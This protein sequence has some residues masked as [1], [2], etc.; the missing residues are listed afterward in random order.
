M[1]IF[2]PEINPQT[3]S[4][5]A[6]IMGA[7]SAGEYAGGQRM[8]QNIMNPVNAEMTLA[9]LDKLTQ[10]NDLF[11]AKMPNEIAVSQA[12]GR[13]AN[14]KTPEYFRMR[15]TGENA[16]DRQNVLKADIG[17]ATKESDIANT[18][19][20]NKQKAI[21]RMGENMRD[22]VAYV[23]VLP[24]DQQADAMRQLISHHGFDKHP[25][26]GRAWESFGGMDNKTQLAQM[27][28]AAEFLM[29]TDP[30]KL[31]ALTQHRETNQTNLQIAQGHDAATRYAADARK[32]D[33][34]AE[35]KKAWMKA[36]DPQKAGYLESAVQDA[37][38]SGATQ[39]EVGGMT[40]T[41]QQAQELAKFY[42][43]RALATRSVGAPQVSVPGVDRTNPVGSAMGSLYPGSPLG[44]NQPAKTWDPATKT[45]K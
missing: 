37:M 31:A 2:Q 8:M 29:N 34:G 4:T 12:L 33:D 5:L 23:S 18:L 13:E 30:A 22:M 3:L 9:N 28:K 27:Q 7:G 21:R 26:M 14:S 44:T 36:N 45:W 6:D 11:R 20:E 35:F 16:I 1:P 25:A 32:R 19:D 24:P 17:E 42:T 10:E 41:L 38:T 40:L 43:Q 39:I 15:R